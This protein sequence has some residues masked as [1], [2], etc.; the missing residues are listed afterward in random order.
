MHQKLSHYILCLKKNI[1]TFCQSIVIYDFL[2]EDSKKNGN[3]KSVFDF[4]W[5]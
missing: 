1:K 3:L 4:L 2:F 5:S